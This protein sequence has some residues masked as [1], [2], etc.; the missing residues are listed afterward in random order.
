MLKSTR[1]FDFRGIQVGE[2]R[3]EVRIIE[4]KQ[5]ATGTGLGLREETQ[6]VT[7]RQSPHRCMHTRT[8]TQ[9]RERK[10][11]R[12]ISKDFGRAHRKGVRMLPVFH[13]LLPP[14]IIHMARVTCPYF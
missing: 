4:R 11:E 2:K 9:Q 1:S 3:S 6:L 7:I 8:H 13:L 5:E 12:S 10:Y 14:I